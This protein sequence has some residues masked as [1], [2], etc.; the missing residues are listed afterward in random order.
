MA[1]RGR[2]PE[3][4]YR[5]SAKKEEQL[6]YRRIGVVVVTT[7]LIIL[8]L[9]FWGPSFINSVGTFL[10]NRD[11]VS[12]T[13][14][15]SDDFVAGPHLEIIPIATNSA[16]LDIKG[17]SQPK[18]EIELTVNDV[19]VGKLPTKDDGTFNFESVRLRETSNQIKAVIIGK[20]GQ[21]SQA[22]TATII[23]DKTPPKLEVT[24][25]V[26]NLIVGSSITTVR[27]KGKTERDT[28]VLVNGTQVIMD[29]NY[30][31]DTTAVIAPGE[32]KIKIQAIDSAGN[33]TTVERNVTSQ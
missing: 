27:V 20:E 29:S 32:N 22:A 21:S 8:L 12:D 14:R 18:Q 1:T 7:F 19:L 13:A 3:Y 16:L 9:F 31:F 17:Y 28:L 11:P 33:Q 15:D 24:E 25:P 4:N 26:Q 30:S 23:Y 2:L 10:S 5:S 6:I